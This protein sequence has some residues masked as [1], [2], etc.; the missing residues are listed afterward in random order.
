MDFREALKF[1]IYFTVGLPLLLI[2]GIF[3]LIPAVLAAVLNNPWCLL[4]LIP[5][6]ISM[7]FFAWWIENV[8][9]RLLDKLM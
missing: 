6:P 2:G 5:F 1:G 9:H 7:A 3:I 4:G 8:V